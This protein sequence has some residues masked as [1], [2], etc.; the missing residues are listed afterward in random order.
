M[1]E[2]TKLNSTQPY[3]I[4]YLGSR[5][6]DS[7]AFHKKYAPDNYPFDEHNIAKTSSMFNVPLIDIQQTMNHNQ[8]YKN[9]IFY[10]AFEGMNPTLNLQEELI[11]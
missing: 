1:K 11:F 6:N 5:W 3:R 7:L 2:L 4:V 8:F 9:E 10:R